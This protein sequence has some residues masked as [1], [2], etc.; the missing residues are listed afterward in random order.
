MRLPLGSAS[1]LPVGSASVSLVGNASVLP[2]GNASATRSLIV[3]GCKATAKNFA[4]RT[5]AMRKGAPPTGA[6][7]TDG[8]EAP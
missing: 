2:V 4:A 6:L 3:R 5:A 7:R 8:W 1:V